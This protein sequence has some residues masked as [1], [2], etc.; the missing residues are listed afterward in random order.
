MPRFLAYILALWL[1]TLYACFVAAIAAGV[2][3]GLSR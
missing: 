2:L 3:L 1:W